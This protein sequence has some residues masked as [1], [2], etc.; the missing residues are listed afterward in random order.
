MVLF[1]GRKARERKSHFR[2]LV[3]LAAADGKLADDEAK[4]LAVL[5]AKWGV[6]PKEI[7]AVLTNPSKVKEAPPKEPRERLNQ[8]VE[9]VSLMI[10]D[11]EIDE[12]EMDYCMNFA[13]R[14]GFRPSAVPDMVKRLVQAVKKGAEPRKI[15]IDLE[16]LLK[17]EG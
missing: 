17:D 12:R 11:G 1:E 8:L 2:N 6:S 16:G 9:L 15:K 4:F 3:G 14:M 7:Q 10:V 13:M 5:G